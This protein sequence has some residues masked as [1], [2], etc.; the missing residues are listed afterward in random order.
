[1]LVSLKKE[2]IF[3][4]TVPLKVQAYLACGKPVLA[5]LDG[6]GARIIREAQAGIAVPAESPDALAA[7][8]MKLA[9]LGPERLQ[10]MGRSARTYYEAHFSRT[11]LLNEFERLLAEYCTDS[12]N[13]KK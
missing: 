3:S 13:G 7:A 12:G 5:S 6:E 2:P 8:A 4:M 1:M 10:A 9:A 11:H